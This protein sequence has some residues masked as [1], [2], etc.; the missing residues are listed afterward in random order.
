MVVL[1][2]SSVVMNAG[3]GIV[4]CFPNRRLPAVVNNK[5]RVAGVEGKNGMK[6][7]LQAVNEVGQIDVGIEAF[8][9]ACPEERWSG[10]GITTGKNSRHGVSTKVKHRA[11][12][13]SERLC[14]GCRQGGKH[15]IPQAGEIQAQSSEKTVKPKR[16]GGRGGL[17]RKG[18]KPKSH[19]GFVQLGEERVNRQTVS[20]RRPFVFVIGISVAGF[21]EG[22]AKSKAAVVQVRTNFTEGEVMLQL[23]GRSASTGI[24]LL[25]VLHKE[26]AQGLQMATKGIGGFVDGSDAPAVVESANGIGNR[27]GKL[28]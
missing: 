27:S 19:R 1:C 10:E 9:I 2:T 17:V 7:S 4:K 13:V 16:K 15:V 3:R 23:V 22:N 12:D 25:E 11:A 18:E 14:Q 24:L 20:R 6:Q 21:G 28:G 8:K 26:A 5:M